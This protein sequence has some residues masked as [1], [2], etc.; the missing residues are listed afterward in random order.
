MGV[1]TISVSSNDSTYF[2]IPG[3]TGSFSWDMADASD[4]IYGQ[5]FSSNQTTLGTWSCDSNAYWKGYAGYVANF[6]KSGTSTAATGEAM[7]LVSGLTYKI[8]DA[9]KNVWDYNNTITVYDGVTDVTAQVESI[10]HLFG[11]ITFL[12]I[13]T[14]VGSITVD[15]NYFP[16]T[17]V[18]SAREFTLTMNAETK[19]VTSYAVAQANGGYMEYEPGLRTVSIDASGFFSTSNTFQTILDSR[20][21]IVIEINPDGNDLSTARGFFKTSG[22]GRDGDVG[23]TSN[24]NVNFVLSVPAD[25]TVVTPF[26]WLHESSTT[27]SSAVQEIL[28]AWQNE[29]TIYVKSLEDGTNG[30]KGE[31]VI[32]DCSLSNSVDGINEF[33]VSFTG[34][35]ATTSLP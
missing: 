33:S 3:S 1:K 17:S 21:E 28:N 15:V 27:L 30:D 8:T 10:D 34:T 23:A 18:G 25:S 13:Y 5:S 11:R 16:M 7:S 26:K 31:S 24:Q 22:T 14:V 29:T 6:L 4:T 20:A 35:G 9:T 19:D 12:G 2:V 32:T